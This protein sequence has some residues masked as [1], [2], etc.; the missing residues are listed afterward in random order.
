MAL[1]RNRYWSLIAVRPDDLDLFGHVHSSRY[2]DYFLAARFDQMGRCYGMGMQEF[3]DNGL[4]WYM[5]K[6]DIS[7]KRGLGLGESVKVY[8][9]L[10]EFNSYHVLIN[11]EMRHPET[12]KVICMGKSEFGLVSLTAQKS[13]KIPDWVLERYQDDA[14]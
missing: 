1:N 4:G 5:L 9:W 14:I 13:T 6:F 8:T 11:F 2:M 12:E 7:Y 10:E 3:L